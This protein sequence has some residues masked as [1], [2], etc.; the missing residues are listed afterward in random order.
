MIVYVVEFCRGSWDDACNWVAGVFDSKEL[1][2]K[3][4]SD[5]NYLAE[6]ALKKSPKYPDV[7]DSDYKELI[8]DYFTYWNLKGNK[9]FDGWGQPE[10]TEHELN[11]TFK[12]L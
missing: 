9:T 10:I 7:D 2:E 4:I 6:L 11:D 1:A 12:A 8:D 3:F 5:N